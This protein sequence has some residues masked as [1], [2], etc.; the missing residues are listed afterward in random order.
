[1]HCPGVTAQAIISL[2]APVTK[3][4]SWGQPAREAC[5]EK[6]GS[7]KILHLQ[8]GCAGTGGEKVFSPAAEAG[9]K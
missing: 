8:Q 3:G 4:R 2:A 7:R 9:G 6:E 1:M 5:G